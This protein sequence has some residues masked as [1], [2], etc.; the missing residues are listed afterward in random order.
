MKGEKEFSN[1]LREKNKKYKQLMMLIIARYI[2]C[3]AKISIAP[4]LL[5]DPVR[6]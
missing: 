4:K 6:M 1:P 5:K 2:H 3:G